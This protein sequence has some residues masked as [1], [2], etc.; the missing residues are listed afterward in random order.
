MVFVSALTVLIAALPVLAVALT[1]L[2]ADLMVVASASMVLVPARMVRVTY[3]R[4]LYTAKLAMASFVQVNVQF[5][6]LFACPR[7]FPQKF[8]ARLHAWVVSETI[9]F[10]VDAQLLPA[11]IIHQEL[12]DG[13]QCFTV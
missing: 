7:R 10:N 8:K 2:V 12:N 6:Y 11:V 9:D 1:V 5:L 4:V 3:G 13:F